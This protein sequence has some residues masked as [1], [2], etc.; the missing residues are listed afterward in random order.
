MYHTPESTQCNICNVQN[1]INPRRNEKFWPILK[2]K[3]NQQRP[4]LKTQMLEIVT[5]ITM[6]S[7]KGKYAHNKLN[8]EKPQQRNLNYK[9]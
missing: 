1:S 3:E 4:S 2:R 5:V 7:N 9:K 8:N 6:L